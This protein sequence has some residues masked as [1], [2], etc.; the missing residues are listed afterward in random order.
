MINTYNTAGTD[1]DKMLGKECLREKL[2]VTS[3]V[4]DLCDESRDLK[5]M[6]CEEEGEN[7]TEKLTRG[8]RRP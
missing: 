8:I 7:N 6:G 4:L 2:W 5:M 1:T 3:D